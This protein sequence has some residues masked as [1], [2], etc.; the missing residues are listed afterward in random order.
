MQNY[1]VFNHVGAGQFLVVDGSWILVGAT[2]SPHQLNIFFSFPP[3]QTF[4][5]QLYRTYIRYPQLNQLHSLPFLGRDITAPSSWWWPG[6]V[7]TSTLTIKIFTRFNMW[8]I[9]TTFFSFIIMAIV[10]YEILN[11]GELLYLL[12]CNLLRNNVRTIE[13][14][15]K[16][17]IKAK[18]GK[19]FNETC[20]SERRFPK[21]A[22]IYIYMYIS[23]KRKNL[24]W[25]T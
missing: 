10:N 24:F 25:S 16:R 15:N 18:Y 3:K 17:F 9:R 7:E 1:S 6:T 4:S 23:F 21:F 13:K 5:F 8:N 2:I 14:L 20:I 22:N 12:P 19:I 11:I